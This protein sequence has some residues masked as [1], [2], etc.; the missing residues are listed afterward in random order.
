MT[1]RVLIAALL[2]VAPPL[3]A[4][5]GRA[6]PAGQVFTYQ[7]RD[8]SGTQGSKRD[9]THITKLANVA[10]ASLW[11][12]W[13]RARGRATCDTTDVLFYALR[14]PEGQRWG[15]AVLI[16][17]LKIYGTRADT[18][19]FRQLSA[20]V[21]STAANARLVTLSRAG[22]TDTTDVAVWWDIVWTGGNLF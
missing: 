7:M 2:L 20:N 6:V 5:A 14:S 11:G 8:S 1:A 4:Q 16:D 21:L 18:L 10:G 3:F 13:V 12:M 22:T 17:S 9:T 19:Y 15:A